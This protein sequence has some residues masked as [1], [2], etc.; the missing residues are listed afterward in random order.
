MRRSAR[1][2]LKGTASRRDAPRANPVLFRASAC[3]LSNPAAGRNR[4]ELGKLRVFIAFSDLARRLR[5]LSLVIQ[6]EGDPMK[7]FATGKWSKEQKRWSMVVAIRKPGRGAAATRRVT[8][9]TSANKPK[10]P[11]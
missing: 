11:R 9:D 10:R 7:L 4:A 1:G 6:R 8:D 2:R 5:F 3:T